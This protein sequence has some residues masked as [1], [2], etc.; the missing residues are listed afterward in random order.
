MK[1]AEYFDHKRVEKN[2]GLTTSRNCKVGLLNQTISASTLQIPPN[3]ELNFPKNFLPLVRRL[4]NLFNRRFV[5][6]VPMVVRLVL[7]KA[8]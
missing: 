6:L 5:S 7:S 2:G 1:Q 8:S 3:H 4:H